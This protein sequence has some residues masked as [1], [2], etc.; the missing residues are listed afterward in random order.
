MNRQ[1]EQAD[2]DQ[3][4]VTLALR[5]LAR[6]S[7]Q[8]AAITA[9]NAS[10]GAVALLDRL[11]LLCGAQHGVLFLVSQH[12]ASGEPSLPSSLLHE[13]VLYPLA[14]YAL[15]EQEARKLLASFSSE[16]IWTSPPTREPS[17]LFWKLP[18]ALSLSNDDEE[19]R[20][21]AHRGLTSEAPHPL[22]AL[23]A[24][25]WGGNTQ[26]TRT[27]A[28]RKGGLLLP[29]VADAVGAVLINV[30]PTEHLRELEVR[31]ERHA[32]LQTEF[33][34][35][36][37]LASVSHELRS[38]LTSIKG[39]AATL[40]RHERRISHEERHEFLVAIDDA[41]MR[42]EVVIDRLLEMSQLE[43]DAISLEPTAVAIVSLVREAIMAVERRVVYA[44]NAG[45]TEEIPHLPHQVTFSLRLE[46][47]PKQPTTNE[48]CIQGD[49]R[50]LRQVL[51]NLF[52]NAL[53]YSSDGGM[54][55]VG[56]RPTSVQG[57][58][59]DGSSQH[60]T[61][62]EENAMLRSGDESMIEIWVCDHGIGISSEH[63]PHVFDR[64]YRVDT[65][66]TREVTGL[67]LGLAI[68]KYLVELHGGTI[69]AESTIGEGST[70]HVL[71]PLDAQ[72]LSPGER[73]IGA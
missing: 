17:W 71:L 45:R 2:A 8:S 5:D 11:V 15:E 18:I 38:P 30:L 50:R 54:V 51:D 27:L 70:F 32:L 21:K 58:R 57:F 52:E 53:L 16:R 61:S 67:G 62:K 3:P 19:Q 33:L 37:V 46:D 31:A 64:F 59:G 47:N 26:E 49:R 36:E 44:G 55:E 72:A 23:F 48:L 68:G 22:Q 25:G 28:A 9:N 20:R 10:I 41:S 66:L 56:I 12:P 42:L 7:Q 39:Y 60:D 29:L 1:D 69:W 63:L 13:K 6:L 73:A 34:K 40:L 24:F 35:A 43:T 65:Q 14:L 4:E